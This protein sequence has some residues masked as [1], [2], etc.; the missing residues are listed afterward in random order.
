M[1][2]RP[3]V[4]THVTL[5]GGNARARLLSIL[6]ELHYKYASLGEGA[7]A[8]YIP[9]LA[10]ANPDWFGIS[11]VTVDG[12]V[13][14][15][16]DCDRRFTIQSA[17]KPFVYAAALEEH[18]RE[19]VLARVGVEP[20]GDAFNSIIKL[21]EKSKRPHNPMVNAG[22]IAITSLIRGEGPTDKLNSLLSMF[23]RFAGHPIDVDMAVFM[24]ERTTGHRNRALAHLMRNFGMIHNGIDEALDLYFQQCSVLVTSRDLATMAGSLANG[25][26]NPL[27]GEQVLSPEYIRDVLSVMFTCGLY[28]YAG[29]WGYRVGLPAK[30]GVGGAVFAVVPRQFG[31]AV[32]SP[33]LDERGNSVRGI[34]V[35]EELSQLCGL[36]VFDA[37][38][39]T[40]ATVRTNAERA[41]PP[42][43]SQTALPEPTHAR[44]LPLSS[45][46]DQDVRSEV[47]VSVA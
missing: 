33:P 10:K 27:T 22:A 25:G 7:V 28:D 45:T 38:M 15:V 29:E 43:A 36:H 16:G 23:S 17:S 26:V 11:V 6:N 46:G 19:T 42:G 2:H 31:V 30:S 12:E 8:D 9:E 41:V 24:S 4:P 35:C 20:T 39:G 3:H 1:E 34:R 37:L 44:S 14:E 40:E 5:R 47:A 18:G 13:Y 21:D 32:F